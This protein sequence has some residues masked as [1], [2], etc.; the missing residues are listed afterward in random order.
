MSEI[1]EEIVRAYDDGSMQCWGRPDHGVR[2]LD[3]C[4]RAGLAAAAPL[5]R[6][7]AAGEIAAEIEDCRGEFLL[8]SDVQLAAEIARR[9][10]ATPHGSTPPP[11]EGAQE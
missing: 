3:C 2:L 11:A 8:N 10:G 9:V 4:R 5:I 1:S 7:A 6:Q